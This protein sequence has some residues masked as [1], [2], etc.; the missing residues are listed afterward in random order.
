MQSALLY[1]TSSGER[2]IRVMNMAIPLTVQMIDLFNYADQEALINLI[3]KMGMLIFIP[4][5]SPRHSC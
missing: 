1:T 5:G 3:G 2:R 4:R